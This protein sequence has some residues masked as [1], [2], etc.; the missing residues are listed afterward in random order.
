[1]ERDTL[2]WDVPRLQRAIVAAE[3]AISL[4][5]ADRVI[6]SPITQTSVCV[7]IVF[8]LFPHCSSRLEGSILLIYYLLSTSQSTLQAILEALDAAGWWPWV[9]ALA[10]PMGLIV[11][12]R[13]ALGREPDLK[14]TLKAALEDARR[15][16]LPGSLSPEYADLLAQLEAGWF[17][18]EVGE[19]E[20][21]QS[22]E[23]ENAGEEGE[24]GSQ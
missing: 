8:T 22:G 16:L 17:D 14:A 13:S 15:R 23:E 1:M 24:G 19:G 7:L 20:E 5:D 9:A 4:H 18:A 11:P 10:A 2:P 6:V 3:R 21:Q 12:L